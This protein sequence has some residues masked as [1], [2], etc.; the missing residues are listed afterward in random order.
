MSEAGAHR[1]KARA[2][3]AAWAATML[4]GIAALAA[5]GFIFAIGAEHATPRPS[6]LHLTVNRVVTGGSLVALCLLA[7]A[8]VT[9]PERRSTGL[10]ALAGCTLLFGL[11]TLGLIAQQA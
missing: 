11:L 8:G 5:L 7:A 10:W 2:R 9:E 6:D 1:L 3:T 4:L